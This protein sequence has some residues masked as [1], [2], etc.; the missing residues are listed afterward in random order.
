[1]ASSPVVSIICLSF[2]HEKYIKQ[3]LDG[4]LMQKT[5]FPF[6]VLIN[7]DC[8]T[9]GTIEI[10]REYQERYPNLIRVLFHEK[11]QYSDSSYGRQQVLANLFDIASGRYFAFCE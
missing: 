5:S 9:D 2:N 11:N 7:D 6:E 8:S 3:C 10:L 1:M 4:F